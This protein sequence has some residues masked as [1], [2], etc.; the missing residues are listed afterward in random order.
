MTIDARKGFLVFLTLTSVTVPWAVAGVWGALSSHILNALSVSTMDPHICRVWWD[1]WYSWVVVGGP[2]GRWIVGLFLGLRITR[3]THSEV[4]QLGDMIRYPSI[5][6][7]VIAG[8]GV[9]FAFFT[10]VCP[11]YPL[12]INTDVKGSRHWY[13][14][15]LT[16]YFKVGRHSM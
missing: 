1:N 5:S 14:L 16:M 15:P 3:R 13:S 11:M 4:Y 9:L 2:P 7:V 6:L 8:S 12:C 10:T